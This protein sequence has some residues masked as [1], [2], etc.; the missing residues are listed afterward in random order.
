[1]PSENPD[2]PSR[3]KAPY[4][5]A[6]VEGI[7]PHRAPMRMIDAV[8]QADSE[9]V[10]ASK[11]IPAEAFYLKGHFPGRPVVPGGLLVEAMAQASLILYYYNFV[12]DE[13]FFL[14]KDK[15]R[16]Y[17]PVFPGSELRIVVTKV[18]FLK[19][20]GIGKG[21][22]FVGE[23]KVAE[24]EMAFAGARAAELVASLGELPPS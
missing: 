15:S 21:E 17:Q 19:T 12:V 3:P 2:L 14:T 7:L 11:H 6:V 5:A 23:E 1:M 16:F 24:S 4:G 8:E 22:V 18:K 9:I 13:L 10:V 20:M